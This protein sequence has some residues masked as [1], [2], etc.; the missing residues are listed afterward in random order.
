MK[1]ISRRG[2]LRT[3]IAGAGAIALSPVA[4]TSPL[5]EQKNIIHRTLGKTGLKVPVVS[6]GVMRSDNSSL[7]RAAHDKGLRLFDTA[8]GYLGGNSEIMLGNLFR[9]YPRDSFILC[10]KVKPGTDNNGKPTAQTTP[11]KFLE[12]FNVSMSRLKLDYVDILHVHDMSNPELFDHKPLINTLK[13]L[14]KDGKIKFIGFST[15]RNEPLV[16]DAAADTDIWDVILTQYNYRLAYLPE[17][18]KAIKKAASAGIGIIAMKTMA[19]GGFLDRDKTKRVNT[20]AA[21]KWVLSNPDISTAIPG[22][23]NF[24]ELELNVKVL[25]DIE[26]TENEKSDLVASLNEPG[27]ICSGCRKCLEECPERLQIPE[28]MRAYMYAYGYSN[29]AMAKNLLG[30]L[31]VSKNPCGDCDVCK[32]KCSRNFDV[33]Q[34][35]ADISRLS[36]IPFDFLA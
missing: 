28:I 16:I 33:R 15:H 9:E 36:D 21:L 5:A 31:N 20:T 34:K 23:T 27:L 6:F 13:Q 4:A 19:G 12:L 29:P 35:I 25:E 2:F 32:V 7:C 26:L 8:N 22:M 3:G 30:E 14:K 11:E 10:T 17:L 18:Q 1:Q 24:D